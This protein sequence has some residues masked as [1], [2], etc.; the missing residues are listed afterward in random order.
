MI[1][2]TRLPLFSRAYV[3]KIGEPGD[4][5]ILDST[6]M[7]CI[8]Y[9]LYTLHRHGIIKV[10]PVDEQNQPIRPPEQSSSEGGD[11]DS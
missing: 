7:K 10:M 4:E 9:D 8:I 5:A 3:E 1:S 2:H 11:E 6:C